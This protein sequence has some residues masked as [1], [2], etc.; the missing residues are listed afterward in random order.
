MQERLQVRSVYPVLAKSFA[1]LCYASGLNWARTRLSRRLSGPCVRILAYHRV[2]DDPNDLSSYSI[3][4]A[5]LD[6]HLDLI[7]RRFTVTTLAEALRDRTNRVGMRDALVVTFDDGYEDNFTL[8]KPVLDRHGMKACFFVT[9]RFVGHRGGTSECAAGAFPR[10]SWDQL[11]TLASEGFEIGA[12][13]R[14]HPN[15]L[16]LAPDRARGEI[17]GSRHDLEKGLGAPVRCF[18]YPYGKRGVHFDDATKAVVGEQFDL[19]C[20]TMRGRNALRTVDFLEIHRI[21]VHRWWTGFHL[22]RELEGTFDFLA[23]RPFARAR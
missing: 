14:T 13:T 16:R 3:S 15:L 2:N 18:A 17:E 21:C 1:F 20:T 5:Q 9:S 7:K 8:A 23:S 12:H 10:M 19:C 11:R 6:E 22:A 4:P